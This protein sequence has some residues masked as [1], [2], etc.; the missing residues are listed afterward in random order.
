MPLIPDPPFPKS[1]GDTL[2]SKDWN[3]AVNE[4]IRLDQAKLNLAGGHVTGPLQIDGPVGIGTTAPNR[5]LTIQSPAGTYLNVK[6]NNGAFEV[7]VGA[8]TGGGILSTM[9]NHDLQLRAGGN[10]TKMIIKADGKVG[11]GTQTP[12]DKLHV[13]AGSIYVN[14]EGQGVV[15]D[16][17]GLERVGLMKYPG[18]EGMLIGDSQLANPVRLGRFTGGN[19]KA[20]TSVSADLV[21]NSSGFVGIGTPPTRTLDVKATGIKLGLEANGGGQLI[22]ANNPNDNRIWLEAF[23]TTGNGSAAELL[24]TGMNGGNV[25]QLTFAADT[26]QA[27]GNLRLANSDIYFTRTDHAHT[28]FGN[29]LGFAAI[30][31]DGSGTYNALMILGRTVSTN[32]LLR[33]VK[34][35]DQFWMNGEA[36]KPNGGPWSVLS[37]GRLKKNIGQLTGVLDKLLSLRGVS[38]EWKDP[39]KHGNLSG[40]KMGLVAQDVEPVFPEWVGHDLDGTKTLSIF[41]FE[42]LTIEAFRELKDEIKALKDVVAQLQS[43]NGSQAR[44]QKTTSKTTKAATRKASGD[45]RQS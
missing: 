1:Q 28:G 38:F 36:F 30:E 26:T 7:L 8:D 17:G 14:G 9:T 39:E 19:I 44:D 3:D 22:L 25:P 10:S 12:T 18:L 43:R 11:V 42:A 34:M 2:R 41:G 24:L 35:W 5:P 6:G 4:I 23:N 40:T 15:V 16:A 29:N 20:P 33:V 32:P 21:I 37:D 31:N 27:N 13:E 45:A